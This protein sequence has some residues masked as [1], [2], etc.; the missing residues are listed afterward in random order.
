VVH[1]ASLRF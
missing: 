1:K